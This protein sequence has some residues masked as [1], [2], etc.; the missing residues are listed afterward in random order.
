M[1]KP[2]GMPPLTGDSAARIG[3]EYVTLTAERM[4]SGLRFTHQ[5]RSSLDL[6]VTAKPS[7]FTRRVV[8]SRF[9]ENRDI[10]K[11]LLKYVTGT[12]FSA[13][14]ESCRMLTHVNDCSPLSQLYHVPARVLPVRSVLTAISQSKASSDQAA[15]LRYQQEISREVP[16]PRRRAAGRSGRRPGAFRWNRR[17]SSLHQSPSTTPSGYVVHRSQLPRLDRTTDRKFIDATQHG[18]WGGAPF[19]DLDE[20]PRLRR[21]RPTRSSIK[22]GNA[23]WAPKLQGGYTRSTGSSATPT[24]FSVWCRTVTA[25]S[26]PKSAWKATQKNSGSI[27]GSSKALPTTTARST[28]KWSPHEYAKNFEDANSCNP[29]AA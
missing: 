15:E 11:R 4:W 3:P 21:R 9:P 24:A 2:G 8:G 27:T 16:H 17:N 20:G 19:E 10:Y 14:P 26:T 18:D 13:C 6:R 22:T 23:R 28:A 1:I 12:A 5:R 29:R 25:C 7:V